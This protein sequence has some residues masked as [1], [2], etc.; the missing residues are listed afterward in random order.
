[1]QSAGVPQS[2]TPIQSKPKPAPQYVRHAKRPKWGMGAFLSER[3]GKRSYRFEDGEIRAFKDGYFHFLDPVRPPDSMTQVEIQ[4]L[5]ATEDGQADLP[6]LRA[7]LALFLHDYPGGFEDSKWLHKKRG[8]A[9]KRVLKR[10]REPVLAKAARV[11]SLTNID[12]RIAA[13][14]HRILWDEVTDLIASTDLVPSG[15]AKKLRSISPSPALSNGLRTFLHGADEESIRFDALR[16]VL[17]RGAWTWPVVSTLRGLVD[18]LGEVPIRPSVFSV[19]AKAIAASINASRTPSARAYE[20]YLS[21]ARHVRDWL[22]AQNIAPKDLFDV[23]DFIWETLRPAARRR[24]DDLSV[25]SVTTRPADNPES[26][27]A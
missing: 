8:V 27:A 26:V 18:P 11:L 23:H 9:V 21:L 20:S 7:Q 13:G 24:I 2:P 5:S 22:I 19:Q 25:T 17:G 15:H 1:M 12:K 10:H 6:G 4:Q 3:D 14:E 16:R